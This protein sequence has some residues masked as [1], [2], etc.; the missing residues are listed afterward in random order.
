MG[1]VGMV[2]LGWGRLGWLGWVGLGRLGRG[3]VGQKGGVPTSTLRFKAR[4]RA[5]LGEVPGSEAA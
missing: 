1:L 4:T 5:G 3:E 2:G